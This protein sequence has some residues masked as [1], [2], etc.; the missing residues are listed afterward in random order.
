M[1]AAVGGRI[2]AV[3]R[4]RSVFAP[5]Y[6]RLALLV[7]VAAAVHGWLVAHTAVTARDGL[8]FARYAIC[9]Q[10]PF[11][12]DPHWDYTRTQ[13]EVVREQQH[14]PGYPAAVWL[15]A[16]VVR[17]VV[18][19][20]HPEAYLL[21]AQLVS[22]AAAVLL[23]VP[24]YFT[25]RM[26]FGRSAGFAAALLI[27]VLPTPA[28]LTSDALT[29]GLYLLAAMTAVML[30]V[31]AV[32]RPGVGGFLLCGLAVGGTYLVR[33]EGLVVAGAV[34]AVAGWLGLTRKWPRDLAAGRVTALLVGVALAAAPYM[35]VIGKFT[36][37]PSPQQLLDPT[38][39]PRELLFQRSGTTRA[40]PAAGGPLFAAWWDAKADAGRD[41]YLWG[42]VAAAGEAV[43]ALHYL[44]AGLALVGLVLL[45]RRVSAE[46]GAWVLVALAG[47]NAAVL[48]H[49]AAKTGYVSERHTVL[50]VAV[51]CV[52]AG[53]ALEPAA[54]ALAS[55]PRVG[56]FW[57]GRYAP[58][59]LLVMLAATALPATLR[60]LHANREGH[61]HV[62]RKLGELA[63]EHAARGEPITVVDPFC[64]AEWY[65]GRTL[66]YVPQDQPAATVR[67][68]VL[69]DKNRPDDHPRLPR[70]DVARQ[71]AAA[72]QVIYHWPEGVPAERAKVKLYKFVGPSELE[73][74]KK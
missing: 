28:R 69:D 55:L 48:V 57:A 16:K 47:L 1:A 70:L 64:W 63:A 67:Y 42:A 74:N 19:R 3:E 33:P 22:A 4:P 30:G 39:N 32:R 36:N 26:L 35:V 8:G 10:S 9:L 14:P 29:E 61:K 23:V 5:D 43:Q 66:Y 7:L 27:S 71:L 58:A 17:A 60:P 37:K 34:G 52:F 54:A 38:A 59:G 45:R 25:G 20:P 11:V 68:V 49:L 41:P 24:V 44:P 15:A 31:R 51:G 13:Y 18:D 72:G 56:R 2:E 65:S 46:P 12:L 50:L 62:G 40:A 6:L 53:A 21:S 73:L